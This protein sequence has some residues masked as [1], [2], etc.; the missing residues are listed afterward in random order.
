MSM[1]SDERYFAVLMAAAR[2]QGVKLE[3][4]PA[5]AIL[6]IVSGNDGVLLVTDD[7]KLKLHDFA[8][9]NDH[10]KDVTVSAL[11]PVELA[12]QM[13]EEAIS[14]V[15]EF[16][17]ADRSEALREYREDRRYIRRAVV[18]CGMAR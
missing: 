10:S 4:E 14:S 15:A 6:K 5:K 1:L 8:N 17:E 11:R 9:E 3:E 13:C 16:G 7:V 2:C 18:A 12:E